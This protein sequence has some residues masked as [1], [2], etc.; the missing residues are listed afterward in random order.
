MDQR[1][2]DEAIRR[3]VHD[4]LLSRAANDPEFRRLLIDNPKSAI[5]RELGI[6]VPD[7][8]HVTILPES[9]NHL[10]IVIPPSVGDPNATGLASLAGH[11]LAYGGRPVSGTGTGVARLAGDTLD[12]GG[13][14]RR[15]RSLTATGVARLAGDTL[16][17]GDRVL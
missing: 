11:T 16:D 2:K 5:A 10:F 4:R 15:P 7:H 13:D 14:T 17:Y 12:Y 3:A 9:E 8:I 1:E 6:D